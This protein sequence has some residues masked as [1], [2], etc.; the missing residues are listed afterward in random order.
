VEGW[1]CWRGLW[2]HRRMAEHRIRLTDEDVWLITAAL[3]AR[4]PM[5]RGV[6]RVHLERL[7]RR[8]VECVPGNPDWILGRMRQLRLTSDRTNEGGLNACLYRWIGA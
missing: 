4:K 6:R 8:L 2:Y 5:A 1:A 3:R 7:L